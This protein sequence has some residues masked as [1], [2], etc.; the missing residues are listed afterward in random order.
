VAVRIWASSTFN[1]V[2]I[3]PEGHVLHV[4][5]T[6]ASAPVITV[7]NEVGH[8]V[9]LTVD[10]NTE[11]FYRTPW[12]AVTD[13]MPIGTG[14]SF[15]TGTNLVRGY[16]VH[17]SVVDPLASPLV[18]QAVDIEIARYDGTISSPTSNNFIYTRNF[19]TPTDDYTKTLPYISGTTP[20]GKDSSGNPIVGFSIADQ[21]LFPHL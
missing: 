17:A 20:N 16:K 3:S 18:A 8:G 14:P 21:P 12:N 6:N 13:A 19:G 4:N 2:W 5:T 10:A 7:E 15:V 11:F 9:N 1:S